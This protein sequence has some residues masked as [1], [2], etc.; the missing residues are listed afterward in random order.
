MTHRNDSINTVSLS[1][2]TMVKLA[3]ITALFSIAIIGSGDAFQSP[4][5][6]S[7]LQRHIGGK[8]DARREIVLFSR[9]RCHAVAPFEGE[10]YCP[11]GAKRCDPSFL[12]ARS[13][14]SCEAAARVCA[15]AALK[16]MKKARG[17]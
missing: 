16:K 17:F 12:V 6:S 1:S 14:A 4:A 11:L 13:M 10:R 15:D 2:I 7:I 8:I 9:L 3:D 5:I